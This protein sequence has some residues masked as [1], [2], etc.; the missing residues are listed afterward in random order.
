MSIRRLVEGGIMTKVLILG[1]KGSG[2]TLLSCRF[3]GC[4]KLP[5]HPLETLVAKADAVR[6]QLPAP[7]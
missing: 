3:R 5:A 4:S 7:G 1:P 6:K 2:K